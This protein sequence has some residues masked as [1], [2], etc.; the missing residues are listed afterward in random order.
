MFRIFEGQ[1]ADEVWL[2]IAR[3]I[4]PL[5]TKQLTASRAG[6]VLDLERTSIVIHN[7]QQRW[8]VSRYPA[9]NPAFAIAEFIWIINGRDDAAFL[10]FFNRQLPK[11]AGDVDHYAGAYGRRLR[12]SLGDDQ[13]DRAFNALEG[14]PLSRQVVLQIWNGSSDMPGLNG[15]PS[16]PDVPCNLVS[17]LKIRSGKLDW[18]QVMRSNDFFLGL[19]HNLVQFTMLQEV[20]AGWLGLLPGTFAL[21]TDSLHVYEPH[22]PDVLNSRLVPGLANT[23][24]LYQDKVNSERHFKQLAD[25]VELIIDP[26][27]TSLE[28]SAIARH[29]NLPP[30][31][32]NMLYVLCAEGARRRHDPGNAMQ[33]MSRCSNPAYAQLWSRWLAR[34]DA[35]HQ[36]PAAGN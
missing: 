11:F 23:D 32:A 5:A 8:V 30:S 35:T 24:V 27:T 2:N 20:M 31:Y 26:G 33:V 29:T 25:A 22:L 17:M 18:T 15:T 10:N 4:V 12:I 7:P 16:S 3:D 21:V 13:L 28:I 1:T 34:V 36:T 6:S 19:P 9:L 14:N